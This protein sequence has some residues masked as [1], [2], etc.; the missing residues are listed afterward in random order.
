MRENLRGHR[1]DAAFE[2]SMAEIFS[3]TPIPK[4]ITYRELTR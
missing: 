2:K 4:P 1:A 3:L